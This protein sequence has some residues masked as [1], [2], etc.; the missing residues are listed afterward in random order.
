MMLQSG[1]IDINFH[2]LLNWSESQEVKKLPLN[3]LNKIM[4]LLPYLVRAAYA[5]QLKEKSECKGLKD[6][7]LPQPIEHCKYIAFSLCTIGE[8]LELKVSD[9]TKNHEHSDA[10]IL[11]LMGSL[12]TSFLAEKV[13]LLIRN[14]ANSRGLSVSRIFEPGAG[15]SKWPLEEQK[16]I[17]QNIDSRRIGVELTKSLCM[18]PLKSLSFIMG[19]DKNLSEPPN[20]TSCE[21]CP[22]KNCFYHH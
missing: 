3:K 12:S 11:D 22:K 15:N 18:K 21:G 9:L 1:V 14:I 6:C 19:I 16:F 13:A 8:G 20:L 17:F 2:Q 4:N 5:F 7:N 10:Y